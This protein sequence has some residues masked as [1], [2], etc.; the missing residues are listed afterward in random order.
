MRLRVLKNL[1]SG[2]IVG[3]HIDVNADIADV[4]IRIGAAALDEPEPNPEP[5]PDPEPEPEPDAEPDAEAPTNRR[6][7]YRRRDLTS[8]A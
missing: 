8:E 4:L 3:D 1:S 2:P 7:R 5:E 6:R